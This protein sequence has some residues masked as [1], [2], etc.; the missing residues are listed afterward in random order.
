FKGEIMPGVAFDGHGTTTYDPVS[1]KY[2]GSWTDSMS[3]GL[4]LSEGAYDSATKTITGTMQARDMTGAM[5]KSRTTSESP[6]ADH[7][8]MTMF[9][10]MP[11]GKEMQT[12]RISYTRRK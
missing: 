5:V 6:D 4:A 3:A 7:R 9:M 1:K 10:P 8:V 12:M 2:V 11:D